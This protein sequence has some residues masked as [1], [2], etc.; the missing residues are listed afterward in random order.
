MLQ[1]S[2]TAPA[3]GSARGARDIGTELGELMAHRYDRIPAPPR[4]AGAAPGA[5]LT[6]VALRA[7]IIRRMETMSLGFSDDVVDVELAFLKSAGHWQR[8]LDERRQNGQNE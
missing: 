5:E 7:S 3:R 8:I 2:Q 6:D 1:R 4:D